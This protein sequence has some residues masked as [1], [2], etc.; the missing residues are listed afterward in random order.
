VAAPLLASPILLDSS[1]STVGAIAFV[2]VWTV[3][4]YCVLFP[5][6]TFLR[7]LG[8]GTRVVFGVGVAA[9][10]LALLMTWVGGFVV[11]PALATVPLAASFMGTGRLSLLRAPVAIAL[12]LLSCGWYIAILVA[13]G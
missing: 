4:S 3:I 2:A 1:T 7:D 6:A 12:L 11:A 10:L 13:A 5:A 8:R 9:V